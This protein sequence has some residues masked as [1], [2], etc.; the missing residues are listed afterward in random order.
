MGLARRVAGSATDD[1]DDLGQA[2]AIADG[3]RMFAPNPVEALLR[4]AQGNDDVHIVAVVLLR[5]VFERSEDASALVVVVVHQISDAQG[6]AR[7]RFHPLEPGG[8]SSEERRVGKACVSTC[9][10]RW[11]PYQ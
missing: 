6:P 9:I 5:R 2:G 7:R 11:W 8:V 3:Q 4:H 1:L 10:S